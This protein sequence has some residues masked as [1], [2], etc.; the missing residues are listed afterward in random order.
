M[1][2]TRAGRGSEGPLNNVLD[3]ADLQAGKVDT[4]PVVGLGLGG[5]VLHP[6]DNDVVD[7]VSNVGSIGPIKPA[8][9]PGVLPGIATGDAQWGGHKDAA[10]VK[11]DS[12]A[13]EGG[14]GPD[15]TEYYGHA[16]SSPECLEEQGGGAFVSSEALSLG[17]RRTGEDGY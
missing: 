10:L 15:G 4:R 3:E 1:P 13:A 17:V 12:P 7:D 6:I 2:G 5:D 9:G 8:T 11:I 16:Q 14:A